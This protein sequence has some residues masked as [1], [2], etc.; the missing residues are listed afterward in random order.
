MTV[1][2]TRPRPAGLE[3]RLSDRPQ[4][5][6]RARDRHPDRP[7]P[8]DRRSRPSRTRTFLFS[9]DGF[10]D[11]LLTPSLLLLV[12]VGSAIVIIT[13]NVDLSVGSIVGLTAYLTGRLFID[14][15][16]IPLIGVFVGGV[17]FGGLLGADQR[18]ARRVRPVPAL[19]IT[20]GTLYIYRGINVAWAGQRPHQ[21]VRPAEGLPRAR[22]PT[23]SSASRSSRSSRSSS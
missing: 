6:D 21:R 7:P 4:C 13:R 23:R 3:R 15:P 10:R 2:D 12:A 20:L 17:L 5:R 19:V 16:G 11:L 8:R 14:I 9:A 18:R 1:I 22:A